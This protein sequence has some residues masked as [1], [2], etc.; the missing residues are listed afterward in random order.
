MSLARSLASGLVLGCILSEPA[1]GMVQPATTFEVR[2]A[3]TKPAPGLTEAIVEGTKNKI[4]LHKEAALTRRD[5]TAARATVDSAD[6][7]AVEVV[8]SEEGRK[9]L[10]KLTEQHQ[11]KPL[12]ILVDGKVIFAPVVRAK[13]T[14]EKALI[15]GKF[16]KA[17]AERIAGRIDAK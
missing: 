16:S 5:I 9:K 13:I 12:A 17:E 7:P 15:T 8:F 14:Q 3:E 10:A 11:G 2:L 1:A 4:Y 6:N